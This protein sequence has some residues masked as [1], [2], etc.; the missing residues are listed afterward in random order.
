MTT[1]P[2]YANPDGLG[3]PFSL[4]SHVARAGD[5]VFA[6]GQVGMTEDNRVTGPDV[7]SQTAQAYA[8][9]RLI[10]E[11]QGASLRHVVRFVV[12]LIDAQDVAE[13][14][15]ARKHDFSEHFPDGGYL[16]NTLLIVQAFVRPELR[17]EIDAT[18]RLL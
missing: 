2:S 7:A 6:A 5:L 18:A 11:S 14:Y 4:Y 12:Y 15:A 13:F 17:V 1:V 10:L 8:N 16:P 9:V 3:Q